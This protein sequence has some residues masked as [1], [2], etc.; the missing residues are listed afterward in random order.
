[1]LSTNIRTTIIALVAVAAVSAP[2]VADAAAPVRQPSTAK[3]VTTVQKLDAPIVKEAGSAGVPGY[4]DDTCG[5]LAAAYNEA[6]GYAMGAHNA[7][8]EQ[9]FNGVA[10][11]IYGQL[12]DNCLVV[13]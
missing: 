7:A 11:H 8:D 3:V 9:A 10:E 12:S 5:D 1:M 6:V 2:G 4:D 13:D